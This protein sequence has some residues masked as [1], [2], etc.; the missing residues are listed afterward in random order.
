MIPPQLDSACTAR[1]HKWTGWQ[2]IDP[3]TASLVPR[4]LSRAER[5]TR[6]RLLEVPDPAVLGDL[7]HQQFL[8]LAAPEGAVSQAEDRRR[9]AL[10][11]VALVA[12]YAAVIVLLGPST[13][14]AHV[15]LALRLSLIAEDMLRSASTRI[16]PQKSE[17][18]AARPSVSDRR[19]RGVH[20]VARVSRWMSSLLLHIDAHELHHMYPF[21]PGYRLTGIPYETENEIGS[22][23]DQT[24][25]SLPG[26]VLPLSE[27]PR[28]RVDL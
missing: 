10:H 17:R 12:V 26:E 15:R 1:H 5:T 25:P 27:S 8:E 22:G 6:Q 23:P 13:F 19:A 18:R 24:R 20:A 16:F 7:C 11:S 3:T 9:L 14:A 4:P 21:V 28:V 2:D